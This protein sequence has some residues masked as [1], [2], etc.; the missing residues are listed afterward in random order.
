MAPDNPGSS[1]STWSLVR[2][3]FSRLRRLLGA[4][5]PK[6]NFS[7]AWR[8]E[9]IEVRPDGSQTWRTTGFTVARNFDRTPTAQ[10]DRQLRGESQPD[11]VLGGSQEAGNIPDKVALMREADPSPPFPQRSRDWVRDDNSA[12]ERVAK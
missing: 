1:F 2:L 12:K 11:G 5:S 10:I 6:G 4:S 8:R 3:L 9:E 7:L